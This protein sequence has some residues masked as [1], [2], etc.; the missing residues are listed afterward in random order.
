VT[1][2]LE[3]AEDDALTKRSASGSLAAR[4]GGGHCPLDTGS[5]RRV[6]LNKKRFRAGYCHQ[7][8]PGEDL[9]VDPGI[10][11]RLAF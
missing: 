8:S 4:R 2:N 9:L 1:A 5:G 11:A 7:L 3:E 10:R 6:I